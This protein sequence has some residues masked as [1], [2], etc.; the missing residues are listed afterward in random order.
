LCCQIFIFLLTYGIDIV[1]TRLDINQVLE[2]QGLE[3][4][5]GLLLWHE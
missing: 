3:I 2:G 4:N 5:D 1:I